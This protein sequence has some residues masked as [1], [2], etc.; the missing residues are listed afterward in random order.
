MEGTATT[1]RTVA[2]ATD[3]D[4]FVREDR[5]R[6][7]AM[8]YPVDVERSPAQN[9]SH[10]VDG[11]IARRIRS[12]RMHQGMRQADLADAAGIS[13]ARLCRIERARTSATVSELLRLAIQLR[14]SVGFFI[15]PPEDVRDQLVKTGWERAP[16]RS[17]WDG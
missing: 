15:D 17:V 13:P 14:R 5:E 8:G 1:A 9:F 6:Q 10:D 4:Q 3:W 16:K 7:R 2:S 11:F 12:A